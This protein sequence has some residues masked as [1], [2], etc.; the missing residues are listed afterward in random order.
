M[1]AKR[2]LLG[3]A[4]LAGAAAP[5]AAQ[6]PGVPAM[7]PGLTTPGTGVY[8]ETPPLTSGPGMTQTLTAPA[9]LPP[10][11]N[12]F[13]DTAPL[14]APRGTLHQQILASPPNC[15]GPVGRNGP[16]TYELF[17]NTGPVWIIGGGNEISGATRFGWAVEGG[18]RTL[19][20]NQARDAAFTLSLGL[21]Y[22]YNGADDSR[23]F[24]V[25]TRQPQDTNQQTGASTP[26]GPDQLIPYRLRGITRSEITYG[27]GRDWFLNGPATT[28]AAPSW[29]TRFGVDVGGRWGTSRVDLV[30]VPLPDGYTRRS[31]VAHTLTFGAH[32][33]AEM[34]YGASILFAGVRTQYGLA[35]SNVIPP[36]DGNF[37]DLSVLL[38]LGVRF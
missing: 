17:T 11:S 37:Q 2:I 22:A 32:L 13:P 7:G 16:V 34:P 24:D 20:F 25:F 1:T 4:L 21:R 10:A 12:P 15:C 30:P 33:D 36:Q 23:V 18:G 38:T 14:G 31:V 28:G 6:M 3:A 5:A 19:L 26:R 29:N 9:G 27:I 8:A 35:F